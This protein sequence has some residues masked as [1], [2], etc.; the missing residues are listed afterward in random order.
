VFFF[1][2]TYN[3]NS[4]L[5]NSNIQTQCRRPQ[6]FQTMNSVRLNNLS[7]KYQRFTTS[8]SEDIGIKK[9]EFLFQFL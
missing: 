6:T 8:D 7:L 3:L 5:N 4:Q 1:C 2:L 9:F